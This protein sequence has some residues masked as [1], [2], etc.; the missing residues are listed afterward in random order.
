M[1]W[2]PG[3][4]KKKHAKKLGI[5]QAVKAS[6]VANAILREGGDEGVAIATGIARA[7]GQKRKEP[8]K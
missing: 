1:P 3:E 2:S 5:T 8:K 4:F 7:K 6:K